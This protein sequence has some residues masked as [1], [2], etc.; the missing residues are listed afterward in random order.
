M[1]ALPLLSET[2]LPSLWSPPFP[3]H[4][5]TLIALSLA[6]VRLSLFRQGAALTHLDSLP[7]HDLVL[8][9]D[10]SFLYSFSK[11]GYGVL[12]NCSL[13]STEVI[14]FFTPGPIC[15]IFSTKACAIG[16]ALRW[17][18]QYQQ[19]CRFFSLPFSPT[20]ALLLLSPLLHVSFYL[21]CFIFNLPHLFFYSRLVL[22]SIFPSTPPTRNKSSFKGRRRFQGFVK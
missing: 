6:K 14:V 10:A 2:C 15:S 21:K 12:A 5:P 22:F 11:G 4:A 1:L 19:V 9:S 20:L 7:P 16:H 3:P 17:S 18:R 8:W 13:Y